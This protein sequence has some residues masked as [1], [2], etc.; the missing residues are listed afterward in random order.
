[1]E[2]K[3]CICGREYPD[4]WMM[5]VYTGRA[6]WFCWDCYKKGHGEAAGFEIKNRDKKAK[7]WNK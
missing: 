5:K 4:R 2:R 7:E 3:C 1:M 6:Y